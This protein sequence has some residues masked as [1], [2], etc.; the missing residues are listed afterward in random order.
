[1]A[2]APQLE[3]N[4]LRLVSFSEEH[5]AERYVAWLNDPDVVR[6]SEQRHSLHTIDSCREFW[7]SFQE[8]PHYYWAIEEAETGRHVGNIDAHIDQPNKVADVAIIIGEKEIWGKG[9]GSEAWNRV[10]EYLL[11]AEKLR[12]VTAGTMATNHGMLGIMRKAGML[13]EGRRRKN[14]LQDGNEVDLILVARFAD[15]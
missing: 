13:E 7:R 8:T 3:T 9:Y 5:L 6:Y 2:T 1:M 12:K 14:H 15:D 10:L 4:R 11:Q